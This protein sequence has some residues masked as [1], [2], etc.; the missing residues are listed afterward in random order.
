MR[1][2]RASSP[3][4]SSVSPPRCG[5]ASLPERISNLEAAEAVLAWRHARRR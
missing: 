5:R 3:W 4:S 1:T 2:T